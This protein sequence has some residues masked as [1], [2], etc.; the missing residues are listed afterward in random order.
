MTESNVV[1]LTNA[2]RAI[3]LRV[4]KRD[5]ITEEQAASNLVKGAL[6][7]RVKKKTGKTPAKVYALPGRD[8][9]N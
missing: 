2:E 7:R 3:L 1:H 8:K 6:A 5:G 9:C 4:A